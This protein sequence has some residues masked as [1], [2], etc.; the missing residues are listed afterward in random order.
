MF[1]KAFFCSY[2]KYLIGF[3]KPTMSSF[4]SCWCKN[5]GKNPCCDLSTAG[6]R[7]RA[8]ASYDDAPS[9]QIHGAQSRPTAGEQRPGHTS[10]SRPSPVPLFVLI[11]THVFINPFLHLLIYLLNKNSCSLEGEAVNIVRSTSADIWD[12]IWCLWWTGCT[13]ANGPRAPL[14]SREI[15]QTNKIRGA[16]QSRL[17]LVTSNL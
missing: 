3:L 9:R 14:H 16:S 2:G 15:I 4:L 1:R 6:K 7:Q 12:S 17:A 13:L 8:S 10:L 11:G 5:R